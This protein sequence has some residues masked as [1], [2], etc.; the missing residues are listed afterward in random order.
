[1]EEL[2]WQNIYVVTWVNVTPWQ[3]FSPIEQMLSIRLEGPNVKIID[4]ARTKRISPDM[5]LI[6]C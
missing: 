6:R 3:Y 1:M 5:E 2:Q 4:C